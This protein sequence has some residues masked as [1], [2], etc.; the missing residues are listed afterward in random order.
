[1]RA[2][3][4]QKAFRSSGRASARHAAFGIWLTGFPPARGYYRSLSS[5]NPQLIYTTAEGFKRIT[6][7][8]RRVVALGTMVLKSDLAKL[9]DRQKKFTLGRKAL[10]PQGPPP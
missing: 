6:G 4:K 9:R 8:F 2:A 10:S 7:R 3:L 1:M 5:C